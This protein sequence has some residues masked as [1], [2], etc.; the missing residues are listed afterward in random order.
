MRK[1]YWED[2]ANRE[3]LQ[4]LS[5]PCYDCAMITGFYAE[6]ADYLLE[7]EIET[8]NNVLDTWFCHNHGNRACKG[9]YDYVLE[10]R[11]A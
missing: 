5:K 1:E 6:I 2:H 4:R 10:K 11:K 3:K 7:E 8:Q 9:A